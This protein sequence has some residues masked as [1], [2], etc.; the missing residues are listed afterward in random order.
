MDTRDI[1]SLKEK[2]V[3]VID[4]VLETIFGASYRN[5]KELVIITNGERGCLWQ[6]CHSSQ[7][8]KQSKPKYSSSLN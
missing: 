4:P 2:K 6:T 8:I 7:L 5:Y 1:F 3:V